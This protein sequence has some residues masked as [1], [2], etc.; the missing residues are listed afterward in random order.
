M[1]EMAMSEGLIFKYADTVDEMAKDFEK[2]QAAAAAKALH[3]EVP[4]QGGMRGVVTKMAEGKYEVDSKAH[5]ELN[6]P[7]I[8]TLLPEFNKA[9]KDLPPQIARPGTP[10]EAQKAP[11]FS[12]A[13]HHGGRGG[14]DHFGQVYDIDAN[15]WRPDYTDGSIVPLS[16]AQIA[17]IKACQSQYGRGGDCFYLKANYDQNGNHYQS[18]Q[19]NHYSYHGHGRATQNGHPIQFPPY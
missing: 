11:N 2:G 14:S 4:L 13:A 9:L 1:E 8:K 7:P 6:L 5:P 17:N 3:D 12:L 10:P 19:V 16:P 15:R 18:D